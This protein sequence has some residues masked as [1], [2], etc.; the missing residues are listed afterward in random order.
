MNILY[1]FPLRVGKTGIGMTAWN[2]VRGLAQAGAQV[3][4]VCGSLEKSF[5]SALGI[6]V[7]ET[8]KIAGFKIPIRFFGYLSA[9]GIHD[10][11]CSWGI[12]RR[13]YDCFHGW[14]LGSLKSLEKCSQEGIISFIERPN[15]HTA[16]AFELVRKE[17]ARLALEVE[18]KN[19]HAYDSRKLRREEAEYEAADFIACPSEFVFLSFAQKGYAPEKLIQHRYGYD[20]DAISFTKKTHS[21]P[22]TFLFLGRGEPRKGVHFLLKAWNLASLGSNARILIA[23]TFEEPYREYLFA[24]FNTAQVSFLGFRTDI[25]NLFERSHVLVLPSV[26]EGSAIVGYEARGA[27]LPVLASTSSGIHG[28]QGV[29]LHPSGSVE[30]LARHL[31]RL[32]EEPDF[33]RHLVE[34]L[35]EGHEIL[36]WR[37]AGID[38]LALYEQALSDRE[39][40][41]RQSIHD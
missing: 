19:T 22:F 1:S 28:K 31:K 40:T 20:L 12:N 8:F 6:Q 14:P 7:V 25:A 39:N 18:H 21:K 32:T 27:G 33:Y 23:G 24:N 29:L 5:E 15:S 13:R 10:R 35:E 30:D 3:T 11:I 2:Q 41:E 36:S 37:Q 26:E 9:A 17:Y 4:L 34:Q 16:T 38:L